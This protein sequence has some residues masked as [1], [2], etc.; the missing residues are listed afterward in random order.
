M[1][2]TGK[3]LYA[4]GPF[5]LDPGQRLLLRDDH[6][7]PLH[8]KAFETLLVLVR[9]SEKVVLKDELLNAVWADT[10][11]EESN[12][13]QNIFVLRKALGDVDGGRRY[14]MTVPGRGYRFA[15]T[16]RVIPHIEVNLTVTNLPEVTH[17]ASALAGARPERPRHIEVANALTL[18]VLPAATE[19]PP[20]RSV[21]RYSS[22]I[23]VTAGVLA[24]AAVVL[25]YRYFSKIP[26][27][28]SVTRVTHSGRVDPW[29]RILSDGSR[30]FLLERD[31]DHWNTMQVAMQGGE[32]QPF[33]STFRNTR[34]F[35]ISPRNSEM[36]IGPFVGRTGNLPLW[37]LP[38][39]GGS[40]QRLGDIAVDDAEF[41]PD[42]TRIA[43][44][45]GDGIYL[46]GT[47]GSTPQ[48]LAACTGLCQSLAWSPD[49]KVI[50][51]TQIEDNTDQRTLWEVTVRDGRLR[52]FLP[53]WN[54][55]SIDCCGR[56]TSDGKYFIFAS[57]RNNQSEIWALRESKSLLQVSPQ[58][59]IQ[60]THGPFGFGEPL[61][62]RDGHT[63]YVEGGRE[64]MDLESVDPLTHQV[65]PLLNGMPVWEMYFS[66]DGQWLVYINGSDDSVWRSRADG[67][68]PQKLLESTNSLRFAHVRW[69]PNGKSIL[70]QAAERG[71]SSS[72]YSISVDG[73][74]LTELASVGHPFIIPDLSPDG[75]TLVFGS[76][77]ET[78]DK[79]P[80]RSVLYLYNLKSEQKTVV[81]AS[82]GL[83][84]AVWSPD[85]RYLAAFSIDR[86]VMR[87]YDFAHHRWSD[88]ARGNYL[89]NP[90]WSADG[91]HIYFQDLL[92]AGEPVFR[93][94]T[95]TWRKEP[96]FTFHEILRSGPQRCL[97][98]G[99]T[100]GGSLLTRFT[101]DG[102]DLYALE[103]D[104]P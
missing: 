81:P 86:K 45:R 24:L 46:S 16:V 31:G 75:Q 49:G 103:V 100:P 14:I 41:S 37:S 76:D 39:V 11:V 91:K 99:L 47:L 9:N 59:P 33:L 56:W 89:S 2:K 8:P 66:H 15:E 48:K 92:T 10:F 25:L 63:I 102:G 13:T 73:G 51:F 98:I 71:R 70:L 88:L 95:A 57:V 74:A 97:F 42:G 65:K 79:S 93:F 55:P 85:G 96:V 50:R 69:S 27:L 68:A 60:L 52:P 18:S 43:F 44:S 94:P 6:P 101:R 84:G 26:R 3:D 64:R 21:S 90:Y 104:L 32:T 61:P 38:L 34:I 54:N 83:F 77:S 1:N 30:L 19:L 35:A 22:A 40:P 4:F 62:S 12:L 67:G 20:R 58:R 17:P 28:L 72:I 82:Q 5:C 53:G 7:V 87:I 78:A 36:L 80:E 23:A 29:G